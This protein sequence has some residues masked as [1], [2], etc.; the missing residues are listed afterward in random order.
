M[1]LLI[2]SCGEE[3]VSDDS[4][5]A[6]L[7][8][9]AINDH[10]FDMNRPEILAY[11]N[12]KSD[13]AMDSIIPNWE[14]PFYQF[15]DAIADHPDFADLKAAVQDDGEPYW[16]YG[17]VVQSDSMLSIS[18]PVLSYG[19]V[20]AIISGSMNKVSGRLT[21]NYYS[22]EYFGDILLSNDQ[23]Y[24]V[25][26][27]IALMNYIS[28]SYA[29]DPSLADNFVSAS[30]VQNC[31]ECLLMNYYQEDP[32]DPGEDGNS[33]TSGNTSSGGNTGG[34][35]S[36]G[37]GSRG[38]GI[39][40]WQWGPSGISNVG[41]SGSAT[42]VNGGID[43]GL[44][45]RISFIF[46]GGGGNSNGD[47]EDPNNQGGRGDKDVFAFINMKNPI[48][49]ITFLDCND[50]LFG[51]DDIIVHK[52]MKKIGVAG[53]PDKFG[54][55]CDKY[56]CITKNEELFNI[57]YDMQQST[58]MDPCDPSK[59]TNDIIGEAIN[60]MTEDCSL[61]AF[62]AALDGVEKIIPDQS[63]LDCAKVKCVYD[64]LQANESSIWCNTIGGFDNLEKS[65]L[66]LQVGVGNT[67]L[68]FNYFTTLNPG[69]RG[70]TT[71]NPS[72]EIVIAFNPK[73]CDAVS[74]LEIA[75]TILH[76]GI[77]ADIWRYLQDNWQ[78]DWPQLTQY[79]YDQTWSLLFDLVCEEAGIS[80]QHQEMMN[81]W[82]EELAKGL[83]DFN[84]PNGSWE[85][86]RYRALGGI[87]KENDPC[88]EQIIGASLWSEYQALNANISEGFN[89]DICP[90]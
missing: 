63:F 12:L 64:Q 70:V 47:D 85:D 31:D 88:S 67:N 39:K 81:S 65:S 41:P 68:G 16:Q 90:D 26:Q 56:D 14:E 35:P 40:G 73:L 52:P 61:A 8:S 76:E 27:G 53:W 30:I 32:Q 50:G 33:S 44:L 10:F 1:I 29:F 7:E 36:L 15:F 48:I 82:I 46:M 72:G 22:K 57:I 6:D 18:A 54:I 59:T 3:A 17:Y 45:L 80:E 86:Y 60:A 78:G 79:S 11:E 42:T 83:R 43:L 74:P 77:H 51:E 21:I 89:F 13:L 62:E 20:A 28:F 9:R 55:E 66:R 69:A 37:G 2:V 58:L 4:V 49:P 34:G 87:Y 23:K 75:N 24:S 19:T 25:S 84:D 71:V 38:G 5:D